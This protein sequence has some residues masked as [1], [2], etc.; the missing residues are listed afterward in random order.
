MMR[1]TRAIALVPCVL[2]GLALSGDSRQNNSGQQS[3]QPNAGDTATDLNIQSSVLRIEFD[4]NLHSRV[5]ALFGPEPKL[6]PFSAT[7]TVTG[8]GRTW[9]DFALTS[10][11]RE[12]VSDAFGSGERLSLT[13]K[14]GDLRKSI[15]VTIYAD[16]PSIAIFDVEYTNE[17]ATPLPFAAGPT[18]NI[19]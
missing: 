10:S 4:H 5:V 17:G 14:S 12:N 16:F 8:V 3:A 13:G 1:C 9:S 11:H 6:T 2:L 19:R 7:E 15:S 18:I